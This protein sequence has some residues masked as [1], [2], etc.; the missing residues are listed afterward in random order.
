MNIVLDSPV[1][2]SYYH[3]QRK[4]QVNKEQYFW[5]TNREL[6]LIA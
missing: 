4:F 2:S 1:A 3:L 6:I 5:V